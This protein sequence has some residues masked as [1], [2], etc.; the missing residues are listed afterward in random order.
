MAELRGPVG[1]VANP[2][3]GR[4]IR[5]ILAPVAIVSRTAKVSSLQTA[6]AA[7]IVQPPLNT[8][9]RANI[10]RSASVSSS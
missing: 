7:G 4:D 10:V 8:E 9:T 5:R 2:Q 6:S 1:L 3:A